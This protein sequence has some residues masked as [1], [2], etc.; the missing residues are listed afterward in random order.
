[1]PVNGSFA[2]EAA[3]PHNDAIGDTH[4]GGDATSRPPAAESLV[5]FDEVLSN[6]R[7][8]GG[9]QRI[10]EGC[11]LPYSGVLDEDAQA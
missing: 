1:M 7:R 6:W 5:P 10:M 11:Y 8:E 4:I 3:R 9:D 2:P